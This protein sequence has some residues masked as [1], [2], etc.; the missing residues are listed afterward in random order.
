MK[1]DRFVVIVM[2]GN[3]AIEDYIISVLI[4]QIV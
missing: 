1:Y 2:I 3:D 4:S